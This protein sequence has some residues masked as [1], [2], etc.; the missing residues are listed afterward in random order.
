MN[1][2]IVIASALAAAVAAPT[3]ASAQT[4]APTPSFKAE[5]C[6]GIAK[7]G[8]N[9]CASTGNNSCGGTSKVNADPRAWVYVPA[10]YCDRI[11]GASATPKA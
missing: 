1:R 4:P 5:K 2:R 7:A 8:K 9:D 10:G 3:L 11:V 6:Y